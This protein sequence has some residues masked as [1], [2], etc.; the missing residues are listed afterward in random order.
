MCKLNI[1]IREAS[2]EDQEFIDEMLF[3]AIHVKEGDNPPSRDVLQEPKLKK[4]Y[5]KFGNSTDLG[6]IAF[7]QNSGENVGAIWL[8]LFTIEDKGWGYI[9]D[10]TPELSMAILKTNRGMGIGSMLIEYLIEE[11][12]NIYPNVSL[13]VDESNEAL[14]LYKRYGFIEH[15][16]KDDSITMILRRSE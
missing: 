12:K 3:Q 14:R 15:E 8:R 2:S 6:Y 5:E 13:S 4:Y 16:K 1:V 11:S 9:N 10:S 7:D